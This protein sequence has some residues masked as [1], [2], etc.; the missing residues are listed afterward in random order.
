MSHYSFVH[1][2]W[3]SW[4]AGQRDNAGDTDASKTLATVLYDFLKLNLE[5]G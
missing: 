2:H 5:T 1:L 3:N 4:H